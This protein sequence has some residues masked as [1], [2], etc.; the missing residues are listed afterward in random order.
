MMPRARTLAVFLAVAA[1]AGRARAAA[2]K[3]PEPFVGMKYRLI[4]PWRGGRAMAAVGTTGEANTYYAGYTGG[5]VWKTTNGGATWTSLFDKEAV[6]SIGAIDVADS[7]PNVVYVGTGEACIRG[8]PSAGKPHGRRAGKR[9]VP[10]ERRRQ[11]VEEGGGQGL[12]RHGARQA[13]RERVRRRRQP[14]LRDGRGRRRE[15]RPLSLRRRRRELE[16]D[17]RRPPAAPPP[18]VLHARGG[19]PAR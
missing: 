11:H 15:G 14:R 13:R 4:G 19:R 8:D 17:D 9:P 10:G 2:D 12:A 6:S 1:V 18:L 7:D 3:P 16:A 5:G